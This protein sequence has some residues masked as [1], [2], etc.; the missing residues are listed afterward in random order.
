M[1]QRKVDRE[2]IVGKDLGEYPDSAFQLLIKGLEVVLVELKTAHDSKFWHPHPSR[3]ESAV[4]LLGCTYR[5]EWHKQGDQEGALALLDDH[6]AF[7]GVWV[8]LLGSH[9]TAWTKVSHL[10]PSTATKMIEVQVVEGL[11]DVVEIESSLAF[12]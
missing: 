7:D 6:H 11:T 2:N 4:L 5:A 9:C 8:R 12:G 1:A 10:G 3:I